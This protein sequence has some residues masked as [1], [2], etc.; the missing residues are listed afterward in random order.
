ADGGY[1]RR[2]LISSM[3]NETLLNLLYL[4]AR[5]IHIVATTVIVGGTLFFELVVPLAI[6]E[7]KTEVQLALFGR[8][9]WVF[10]W[11][12]YTCTIALLITGG[13]SI[14]RNYNVLNGEYVHFL[15]RSLSERKIEGLVGASI[16]NWPKFWFVS[17]VVS[18]V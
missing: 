9:R 16:F 12:V 7:L 5:Y 18:G 8:M 6:G 10:R 11:V 15:A 3:H 14:Y 1:D 13:V 2:G 17:H 4:V